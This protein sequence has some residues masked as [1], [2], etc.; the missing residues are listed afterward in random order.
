MNISFIANTGIQ[1][2][3]TEFE[4]KIDDSFVD[5]SGKMLLPISIRDEN[6]YDRPISFFESFRPV[7]GLWMLEPVVMFNNQCVRLSDLRKHQ[8]PFPYVY[9]DVNGE[10]RIVSE[11]KIDFS[12]FEVIS[13]S[14]CYSE[15]NLAGSIISHLSKGQCALDCIENHWLPMPVFEKDNAGGFVFGPVN[16]ARLKL[17]PIS[18]IKN[19]RHYKAVWAFDTASAFGYT[20]GSRPS[21]YQ[22]ESEKHFSLCHDFDR[23]LD[24]FS[25]DMSCEW[26]DNYVAELIHG[27]KTYA[28]MQSPEEGEAS[29]RFR[30]LIYYMTVICYL[31]KIGAAPDITLYSDSSDEKLV[32]LVLDIGNSRTCGVLFENGDFTKVE[33][34][35]LRDLSEPWKVYPKPFDMRLAFHHAQFGHI[36]SET[37]QFEWKSFLRIGDEATKLIYKSRPTDGVSEKTTNYSSPKRY[38]WDNKQF[39]G[40]WDFLKTDDDEDAGLNKYIYIKGLSEQF[41]S[42]GSLR[43]SDN[44]GIFSSFSRR[45]LM[46]F[47]MI[48]IIQQAK[49]QINSYEFRA[50]HADIDIPRKLNKIIIT[51]PT[52]IPKAEQVTLRKCAEDAYIA[53]LRSDNPKLYYQP[54]KAD[55]WFGMI[56]IIPSVRDLTTSKHPSP[57]NNDNKDWGYDEASCCQFVYLFAEITKRYMNNCNLFFDLYGHVRQEFLEDGYNQKSL[58][59]GSIDMGAG[60]TDLMICSYKYEKGNSTRLTPVPLFWDSFYYAGDDFLEEVVR[61]TIIEGAQTET[62][63][64]FVGPIFNAVCSAYMS[65]PDDDFLDALDVR[66][67][68]M[69]PSDMSDSDKQRLKYSIASRATSERI[70]NFFGKD[71]ALMDFKSRLMRQDFN[72]QIAVPMAIKFLDLLQNGRQRMILGYSDFFPDL[73]PASFILEHFNKHFS[74]SRKGKSYVNINFK[75]IRWIYDPSQL[76]EIIVPKLEPLI[77]QLSKVLKKYHCDI[78][79]LAG[80]PM[81]LKFITDLFLNMKMYP[82]TPDRLIRLNEY[83]VGEWY[84]FADGLGYF[85]DQKSLVAVGAMIGYLSANG[86]LDGF[87]MDVS[88]LKKDMVSTSKYIGPYNCNNQSVTS[89]LLSPEANSASFEV[90]GF[91]FY[92]GCKRLPAETYQARPLYCLNLLDGTDL[93][94]ISFPLKVTITRN[95]SQDREALKVMSI[96]DSLGRPATGKVSFNVQSLANEGTYWLDKGEFV[97]SIN[98]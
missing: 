40:Q 50:K 36:D 81:S 97:L 43:T 15:Y 82:V 73:E 72:T 3:T 96:V 98:S 22:G 63:T 21:F 55:D 87:H 27:G 20:S 90:H 95:Y 56:S 60:T 52:A 4:S 93:N 62:G 37:N 35:S 49:C 13:E 80:K 54:Y 38:L 34:L 1:F 66:N 6:G 75:E 45:S 79:L 30:Y 10:E 51:C 47:V 91:P 39:H 2:Y 5:V 12:Q 7:R 74:L 84:P 86:G 89:I 59:V 19:C 69:F 11:D 58:T 23:L 44:G 68:I 32:D 61:Q 31:S 48:E 85:K 17:V 92:F 88:R 78:V 71:K 41:D 16:W 64:Q 26:V 53:L 18:N 28:E 24:F 29:T 33:M 83:R 70:H 9:K 94:S 57:V 65:L 8:A 76:S 77:R 25:K 67:A 14:F 42:D 46:T